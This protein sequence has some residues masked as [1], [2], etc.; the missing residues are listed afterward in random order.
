[1]TEANIERYRVRLLAL[2]SILLLA[3]AALSVAFSFWPGI[4]D[5]LNLTPSAA[6]LGVLVL[7]VSFVLLVWEK[8]RQYRNLSDELRSQIILAAAFRNRLDVVE[9]LL[10]AGDRLNGPLTIKEVLNVLL[11]AA[12]DLSSAVGGSVALLSEDGNEIE[13]TESRLPSGNIDELPETREV[14]IPLRTETDLVAR[15]TLL[16]PARRIQT[17]ALAL[18]VLDRFAEQAAQTIVRTRGMEHDRASYAYLQ[19]AHVVKSRFLAT[20]SHELRTPLTSIIGFTSTLENHWARL[21]EEQKLE[22]LASVNRQSHKLW[23]LVE[24]ILEAARVELEG[25]A[26]KPVEHDLTRSIRHGIQSFLDTDEA[27]RLHLDLPPSPILAEIDPVILEQ[28]LWNVVDN[29]FRYTEEP[30]TVRLLAENEVVHISVHDRGKSVDPTRLRETIDPLARV[31]EN[32]ESGTGLGLH[33]VHTLM[34]DHG[35]SVGFDND[36][37]GTT[38]TLN[39]PRWVRH[40][41]APRYL[42][43]GAEEAEPARERAGDSN[44]H[45]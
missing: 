9:E 40:K 37:F 45:S 4:L 42:R 16:I 35:G 2:I 43:E 21:E 34:S 11:Q 12:M 44:I 6:R 36:G 23:R 15:L 22:A 32:P 31:G 29:A 30:V 19:A 14:T 5:P 20:V 33:V 24:R 17:D 7:A 41:Q 27:A 8:E 1:M 3:F 26:V 25:V 18:E 10:D 39:F 28:C 13:M 38:V